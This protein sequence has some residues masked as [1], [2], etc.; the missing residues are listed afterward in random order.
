MNK[1]REAKKKLKC[2]V[3]NS[4]LK[5]E[6]NATTQDNPLYHIMNMY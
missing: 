5:C 3:L 2:L 6:V 4:I 1:Y